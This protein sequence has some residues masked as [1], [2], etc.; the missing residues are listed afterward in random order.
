MIPVLM[1]P[2]LACILWSSDVLKYLLAIC[3]L[4]AR[5]LDE[6]SPKGGRWCLPSQLLILSVRCA[7]C[8]G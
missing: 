2:W 7:G 8:S 3:A 1:A 4:G 6:A 5:H